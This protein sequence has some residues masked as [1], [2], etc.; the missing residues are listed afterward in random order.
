[1][2]E[3]DYEK[4]LYSN[5]AKKLRIMH[6]NL[7]QNFSETYAKD[8]SSVYTQQSLSFLLENSRYIFSEPIY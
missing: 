4:I 2:P 5:P 8:Y 7:K 1:M 3:L 6:E